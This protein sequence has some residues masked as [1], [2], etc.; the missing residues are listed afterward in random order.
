MV[1][2]TAEKQTNATPK[3]MADDD[4]HIKLQFGPFELASRERVLRCDGVNLPLG[5]RAFDIL[6]YLAE[7][8]GEVITK[9]ELIDHVWSDVTVEEGSLRVHVAAIRKVLGGDQ[10]GNRYIATIKGRGYS[11]VGTVAPIAGGTENGN[12]KSRHQGRLLVR[13]LTMIGRDEVISEVSDKLR[14]EQFV[15]LLGPG[16]I[17]KTTVALAVARAAAEEFGGE[18][19][20]VDL[21]CLTDPHHVAGAVATSLGLAL[22]AKILIWS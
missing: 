14:H 15:T 13:P 18:V 22:K 2:G 12:D 17:G 11:F 20:F 16:G 7:R 9:K 8:P 10:F 1:N 19:C 5:S 6:I 3:A 21:E 4:V